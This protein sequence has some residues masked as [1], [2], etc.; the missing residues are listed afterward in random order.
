MNRPPGLADSPWGLIGTMIDV[1]PPYPALRRRHAARHRAARG[2]RTRCPDLQFDARTGGPPRRGPLLSPARR[3]PACQARFPI[4]TRPASISRRPGQLRDT[5]RPFPH[6]QEAVDTWW[7]QGGRG[8]VVL[9]TGTGKTF[10]AILAI[11]H[12]GRPTLVVTP[13]IALMN[14]WYDELRAAFGTRRRPARRRL[15]R[16]PAAHRHH[17]RF[18]VHP[19]GT[20]GQSLR[21][22]RLR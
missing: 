7:K 16:P 11:A 1:R 13:T 18:R 20:L 10:V 3:V 5:R 19:S 12:A 2:S 14:Q 9:P 21:P 4:R 6:Q 8:V 22:A 15:L 17:L